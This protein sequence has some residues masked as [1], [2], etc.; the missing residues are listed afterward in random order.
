MACRRRRA[1]ARRRSLL[2][3][4]LKTRKGRQG[5]LG[6]GKGPHTAEAG[7]APA[8]VSFITGLPELLVKPIV[9]AM[10][11][12]ADA[13]CS[14]SADLNQM[15]N[16]RWIIILSLFQCLFWRIAKSGML[17]SHVYGNE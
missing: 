10:E 6:R 3:S 16:A 7:N 2:S 1:K 14:R 15:K 9:S 8:M 4:L 11:C 13:K 17:C 5:N 12:I